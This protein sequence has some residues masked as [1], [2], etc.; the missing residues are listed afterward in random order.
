MCT[1]SDLRFTFT[2]HDVT[3]DRTY[4]AVGFLKEGEP[5]CLGAEMLHRTAHTNGGA[6]TEEDEAFL[7]PR[8]DQLPTELEPY[9]LVTARLNP[10]NPPN[11]VSCF[12]C[13]ESRW[14]RFW[15]WLGYGWFPQCLVLRRTP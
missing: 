8:L 3:G 12:A 2:V 15:D 1:H 7:I 11:N 6:I 14:Y 9:W 13:T 5:H 10:G 4:E